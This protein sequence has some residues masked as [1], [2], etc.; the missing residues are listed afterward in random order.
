MIVVNSTM[1]MRET[2]I[3]YVT[4]NTRTLFI[5]SRLPTNARFTITK[6]ITIATLLF[7]NL[8][9]LPYHLY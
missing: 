8:K 1:V 2:S 3:R 4:G 6:P 5:F 7:T 9:L